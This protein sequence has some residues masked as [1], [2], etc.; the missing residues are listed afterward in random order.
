MKKIFQ[1][2]I[3]ILLLSNI[4]AQEIV[5]IV[6]V[7]S[8]NK[9]TEDIKQMRFFILIKKIPGGGFERLNYKLHAPLQS[10]QTYSDSSLTVLEGRNLIYDSN[11]NLILLGY[12]SNNKRAKSWYHYNDT[13]KVIREDIY[14]DG[15]LVQTIDPDTVKKNK[16]STKYADEKEAMYKGGEKAWRKY[17]TQKLDPNVSVNSVAGGKI[18]VAFMI[19][20]NGKGSDFFL[21]KSVEYVLDEESLRVLYEMPDWEPAFQNGKNV[22]AYRVQPITF[23]ITGN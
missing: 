15:A 22:N 1:T 8:S 4:S 21:R 5:N 9:I 10:V 6:Y 3:C 18:L 23:V 2:I 20:K 13:F 11:G 17:L 7:D 12:Y 14:E 19:N 16:D